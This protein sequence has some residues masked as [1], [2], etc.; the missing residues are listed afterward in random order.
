MIGRWAR[1]TLTYIYIYM[2]EFDSSKNADDAEQMITDVKLAQSSAPSQPARVVSVME[3]CLHICAR[4]KVLHIRSP[5]TPQD[6][7]RE[8]HQSSGESLSDL[9]LMCEQ[10]TKIT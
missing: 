7:C 10:G 9:S 8:I 2:Q 6:L 1:P 5:H 3:H 4:P